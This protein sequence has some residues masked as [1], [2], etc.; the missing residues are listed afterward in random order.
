MKFKNGTEIKA[1]DKAVGV[2][3]FGGPCAGVVVE[4][5]PAKGQP[6]FVFKNN[7]HGAVQPSLDLT[8]YLREDEKGWQPEPKPAAATPPLSTAK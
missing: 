5:S 6:A 3:H 1:G 7:A 2:D 4:G 8:T